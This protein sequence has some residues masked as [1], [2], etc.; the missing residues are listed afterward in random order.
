MGRHVKNLREQV[1]RLLTFGYRQSLVLIDDVDRT[2]AW[3]LLRVLR[4]SLIH[5]LIEWGE[6]SAEVPLVIVG[7][8]IGAVRRTALKAIVASGLEHSNAGDDFDLPVP[9]PNASDEA[10]AEWLEVFQEYATV[11]WFSIIE[12]PRDVYFVR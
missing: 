2:F 11:P 1:T 3:L 4:R 9:G 10:V 5:G 12:P 8:S 7:T 6:D